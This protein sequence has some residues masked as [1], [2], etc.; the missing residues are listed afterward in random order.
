MGLAFA[1]STHPECRQ[2]GGETRIHG[3][4]FRSFRYRSPILFVTPIL[5]IKM[6]SQHPPDP[7][8]FPTRPMPSTL[9]IIRYPLTVLIHPRP[10]SFPF[11]FSKNST[12]GSSDTRLSN[13]TR[14]YSPLRGPSTLRAYPTH[15]PQTRTCRL[16]ASLQ[17]VLSSPFIH[18]FNDPQ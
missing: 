9:P 10:S 11:S 1:V 3:K 17:G 12:R 2:H 6:L 16:L 8:P 5:P 4:S 15:Q 18:P 14:L 7:P 13:H